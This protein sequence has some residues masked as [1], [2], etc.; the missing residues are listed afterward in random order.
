MSFIRKNLD[1]LSP[2]GNGCTV[3]PK[4]ALLTLY[5]AL[6]QVE[7]DDWSPDGASSHAGALTAGEI[8]ALYDAIR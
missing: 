8:T 5:R 6:N 2:E 3:E 4:T 7:C 1:H